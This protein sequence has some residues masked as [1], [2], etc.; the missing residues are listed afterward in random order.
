MIPNYASATILNNLIKNSTNNFVVR[1]DYSIPKIKG[2]MQ[3][4]EQVLINL[5]VNSC[6]SLKSKENSIFVSTKFDK[7]NNLIMVEIKD[8]GIGMPK[9]ILS[10][11]I[12]PFF[13]TKI[14]R[15]GNWT[16]AF[17]FL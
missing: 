3:Q 16:W 1:Y 5:I 6:Q 17:Y 9:E 14:D 7:D 10:K 4:L 15:G 11:I 2:N 12:E 13:T 8:Q